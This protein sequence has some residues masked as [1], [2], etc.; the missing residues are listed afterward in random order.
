MAPF[1]AK[2]VH[3]RF[4]AEVPLASPDATLDVIRDM[5]HERMRLLE[6]EAE[7]RG[8]L[9]VDAVASDLPQSLISLRILIK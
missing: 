7:C 1:F 5:G 6:I 3:S 8:M 4:L 2:W 9:T